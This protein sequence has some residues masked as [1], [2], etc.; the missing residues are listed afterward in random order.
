MALAR[1]LPATLDL[2]LY[3]GDGLSITV[4][5]TDAKGSRVAL[6]G[7]WRASV[8]PTRTSATVVSLTVDDTDEANG[9][10]VVTG[11]GA[12]VESFADVG[13]WDLEYTPAAGQAVTLLTGAV[14]VQR[15]VSRT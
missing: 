7:T 11:T 9:V 14:T 13:V 5:V 10:V 2:A 15:D 3:A 1:L 6:A 8:R 4:T 12:Q